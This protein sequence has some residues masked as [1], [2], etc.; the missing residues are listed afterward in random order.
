MNLHTNG[1]V[2]LNNLGKPRAVNCLLARQLYELAHKWVGGLVQ[3]GTTRH[4]FT[5]VSNKIRCI[6]STSRYSCQSSFTAIFEN[7]MQ[8][9]CFLPQNLHK[10]LS[11]RTARE[12]HRRTQRHT[13]APYKFVPH[14]NLSKHVLRSSLHQSTELQVQLCCTHHASSCGESCHSPKVVLPVL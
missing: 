12:R 14:T 1:L 5:D 8:H 4:S 10:C 6:L 3:L 11:G 9:V 13:C 7:W 2:A